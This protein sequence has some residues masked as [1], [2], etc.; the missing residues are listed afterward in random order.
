MFL[1]LSGSSGGGKTHVV[2]YLKTLLPE[3]SVRDSDEWKTEASKAGRQEGLEMWVREAVRLQ[4]LG[5]SLVLCGQSPFGEL[6]ACPSTPELDSVGCCL[7]DCHDH[8]RIR[9]LKRRGDNC[10]TMDMLCWACWHRM[11]AID[12]QWRQDVIRDGCW[13]QLRWDRWTGWTAGD[14]RWKV[15]IIDTSA[16]S[17]EEVAKQIYS[18]A[19]ATT[20]NP[21]K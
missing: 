19:I 7:L 5:Q 17:G 20:I 16:L 18:V 4:N 10:G 8:V 1:L 9:R 11:H 12:P 15:P 2:Q 3:A 6:L 13:E 21:L 14:P